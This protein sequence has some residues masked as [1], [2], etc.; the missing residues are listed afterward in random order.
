MERDGVTRSRVMKHAYAFVFVTKFTTIFRR[1]RRYDG[2][3]LTEAQ[4]RKE[5]SNTGWGG[6]RGCSKQLQGR[7]CYGSLFDHSS[8]VYE[9]AS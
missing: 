8:M 6:W 7:R 5:D 4:P 1:I 3:G 9:L 2:V